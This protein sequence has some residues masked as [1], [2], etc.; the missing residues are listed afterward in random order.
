MRVLFAGSPSIAV[1]SLLAVAGGHRLVGLLTN[2]ESA[3]GRSGGKKPTALAQ[4]AREQFGPD[5]PVLDFEHLGPEARV[6]V[7][8][9][10]PDL[11]LSFA[12]G[13]IFG[14]RFLALFP[15][16]GINIHPSLLP[17]HRGASPIQQAILDRDKETGVCV[18]R[19][20]EAM[21]SGDILASKR[22]SLNGRETASSLSLLAAGMGAD[23][24]VQVLDAIESQSLSP[25]PQEGE[26]SYCEKIQK[27]DGLL[28]WS[29]SRLELD[30]R[31]RAFDTWPGAYS[32]LGGLRLNILEAEV[33]PDG[34]G[35]IGSDRL[36]R[37]PDGTILGLDK[38]RGILIWAGDGLL[39][40]KKLQ[41][42]GRKVLSYNDFANGV[43]NLAGLRLAGPNALGR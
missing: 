31:I 33:L 7:A 21:D 18:Q 40:L 17:R 41:F 9:L 12:Y 37:P 36:P 30:A 43:R 34:D 20:A 42:S 32:F 6:A 38:A 19:L 16:G 8:A 25:R 23:L 15:M 29:L 5:F 1:S 4:V 14:P 22:I 35:G 27:T 11:L 10:A 2:P 3:S 39:A 26:V 28:D 24:A 13:R